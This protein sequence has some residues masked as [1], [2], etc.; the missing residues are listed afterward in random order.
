MRNRVTIVSFTTPLGHLYP[1]ID[2]ILVQK[3]QVKRSFC[4]LTV[5]VRAY[6]EKGVNNSKI[7][8]QKGVCFLTLEIVIRV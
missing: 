4:F 8:K 1:K 6:I 5:D 7:W 3:K 2:M